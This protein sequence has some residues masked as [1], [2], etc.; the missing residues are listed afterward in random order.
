VPAFAVVTRGKEALIV[1][2]GTQSMADWTININLVPEKVT[3]HKGKD[4]STAIE[5]VAHAGMYKG[6]KAIIELC[7]VGAI[8]DTLVKE[9]YSIKV[10][11][12]SL[13]AGISCMIA[14]L[15][16]QKYAEQ[17]ARGERSDIPFIPSIGFGHPPCLGVNIADA[18]KEDKLCTAIVNE[19]DVVCRLSEF[20]FVPLAEEVFLYRD[21][22]TKQ[23]S[24]DLEEFKKYTKSLG[25]VGRINAKQEEN[26][27]DEKS[28]DNISEEEQLP[29]P[30]VQQRT[31]TSEM[32]A[33]MRSKL[34]RLCVPGEIIIFGTMADGKIKAALCNHDAKTLKRI[35]LLDT[36]VDDHDMSEYSNSMREVVYDRQVAANKMPHK[37]SPV[38]MDA[39]SESEPGTFKPCS[40]CQ[41]DVC[42]PYILKS[43]ASRASATCHCQACGNV[44]CVVCAPA[45][46]T[47][48]AEAMD[49]DTLSDRR[50]PLP[51]YGKFS[52]QR[53]CY[54]CYFKSH[55]L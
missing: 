28:A 45:G 9:G 39:M 50:T 47:I 14:V 51:S 43:V 34:E 4:G 26:T 23:V 2:R 35:T 17:K 5:G 48:P 37:E 40:V 27:T 25:A 21:E 15:L 33:K 11:G 46:D 18:T 53:V 38:H 54:P 7:G 10:V 19:Y 22:A 44:C 36:I 30:P 32:E 42:W 16:K 6:A 13:G 29:S 8:V 24:A 20:N 12:H 55:E 41:L 1:V 31:T 52:P 3:Y 49:V